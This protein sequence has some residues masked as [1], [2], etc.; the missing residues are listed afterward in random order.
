MIVEKVEVEMY[1][2]LQKTMIQYFSLVALM[3]ATAGVVKAGG[4][5]E[6][7]IDFASDF[8]APLNINNPYW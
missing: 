4:L 7:A 8:T 6:V 3:C 1:L 5:V 2:K